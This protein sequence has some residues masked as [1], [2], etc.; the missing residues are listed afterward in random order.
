MRV[1]TIASTKGGVGKTTLA[2]ALAVRAAGESGRVAIVDLDPLGS[3][4]AWWA[5]RGRL[6]NPEIFTGAD[7]ASEAVEKLELA[8]WDYVFIDTPPAFVATIED[9]INSATLTLVPLRASA[10]DLVASEDAVHIAQQSGNPYL[11][12][13]NDAEVRWKT[14]QAARDYLMT[15]GVPVAETIVAHRQAYLAAMTRGLTGPEIDKGERKAAAEIDQLW[16][17]V[18]G[19]LTQKPAN[20]HLRLVKGVA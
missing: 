1:I 16:G 9:A 18:K 20:P 4:A 10:L 13:I 17:E 3:L 15:A 14:T 7:T 11:A 8:G 19:L 2:S 5:R 6:S 12:V